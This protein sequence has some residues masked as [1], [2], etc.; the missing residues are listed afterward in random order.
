MSY[1]DAPRPPDEVIIEEAEYETELCGACEH[2]EWLRLIC[3][4]DQGAYYTI[5]CG[6]CGKSVEDRW[7]TML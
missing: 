5:Y 2:D 4:Y 6:N 3:T 1:E 7:T